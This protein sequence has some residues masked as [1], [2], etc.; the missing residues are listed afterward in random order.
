M[1]PV[2]LTGDLGGWGRGL[3][4]RSVGGM[5]EQ[6]S[7]LGHQTGPTIASE[8]TR[9]AS[10]ETAGVAAAALGPRL[11]FGPFGILLRAV[12]AFAI[13]MAGNL[14]RAGA[15]A[16]LLMI[17]GASENLDG[18]KLET[19]AVA[20]GSDLI[21]LLGVV[22]LLWLWLRY[23]ERIRLRDV[24]WRWGR[25]STFALLLG[26]VV[27]GA[28]VVGVTALLPA[29][30]PP[31]AA[32]VLEQ[33]AV[34]P[35]MVVVALSQ[36]FF[37]QGIPEELL[38]RGWLLHTLR[39]RPVLAITVA[40][41]AF[42]VIHLVS[43]GG[44]ANVAERFIYLIPPLGFALLAAGLL[45]W[46]GSFWA[47]AGVHGGYHVGNLVA[48]LVLPEVSGPLSWIA[49]GGALTVVGLALTVLALRRGREIP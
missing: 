45:L 5:N 8:E 30:G 26:V 3:R 24:G 33:P 31:P 19:L 34:F 15:I 11:S 29:V 9:S 37:L 18:P 23:V 20:V 21:T 46:T 12:V 27:T 14:L 22:F 44:Q 4:F 1:T 35:L 49:V 7:Q 41:L 16:L 6:T 43:G 28:L 32:A 42:T 17:P 10:R 48:Q 39:A 38:F 2:M 13:L 40:T 36:A 47:A 25:G